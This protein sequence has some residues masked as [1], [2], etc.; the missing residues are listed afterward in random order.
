MNRIGKSINFGK[1]N[2]NHNAVG[3]KML[4]NNFIKA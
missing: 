3:Q 2:I 1:L 4:R